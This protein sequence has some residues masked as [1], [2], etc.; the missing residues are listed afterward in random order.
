MNL[1]II[2]GPNGSGKS[3]FISEFIDLF[4]KNYVLINSDSIAHELFRDE[5]DDVKRYKKAFAYADEL[6][7]EALKEQKDILIETV[8]SSTHKD[9][10]Y[11]RCK[12]AGYLI[13]FFYI[14]TENPDI[15]VNR[16]CGRVSEG[17]HDVPEEKVRNRYY[18]SLERI[19]YSWNIADIFYLYDNSHSELKLCV[20]AI[21]DDN[22]LVRAIPNW[23]RKY[24]IDRVD[25]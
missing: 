10:F 11:K 3:T 7:N 20:Y 8:N 1:Y 23:V 22:Y 12:E 13:H 9:D 24:F 25:I 21:K 2:A 6:M 18:K 14:A 17:G 15:N 4:N 19:A 16:V 5:K